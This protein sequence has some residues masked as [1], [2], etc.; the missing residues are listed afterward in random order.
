MKHATKKHKYDPLNSEVKLVGVVE[1]KNSPLLINCLSWYNSMEKY[2]ICDSWLV[3]YMT[4]NG[5]SKNDVSRLIN[6]PSN[7]APF[8]RTCAYLARMTM[9][10]T[11]F[12]GKLEGIVDSKIKNILSFQYTTEQPIAATNVISVQE[13]IKQASVKY[14]VEIEDEIDKWFFEKNYQIVFSL[15]AYL[16]KNKI[17]VPICNHIKA[18]IQPKI[19]EL[20]Q[21]FQGK[22]EQIAEGYSYLSKK[23]AKEILQNLNNLVKD[24]ER[25]TQNT[26]IS[27]PRKQRKKAPVSN[28]KLINK[29]KYQKEFTQLKIT[30]INPVQII[31]A[32]QLWTFNTKYNYITVYNS[33]SSGGLNI[34]GTTLIGY[35]EENSQRK[36]VRK[37]KG[38]VEKILGGSKTSLRNIMTELKTK[39][40]P[41]NGRI[42]EDTILLKV[43]K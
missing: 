29:L 28:E 8:K 30:S 10:G 11:I 20:T 2:D 27:K 9:N 42:N 38:F 40:S 21:A 13:K 34:K 43:L 15:Y 22:D 16:Q 36:K 32:D 7:F 35:S 37:P 17:S 14:C 31:G 26:K 3:D 33:D 6:V 39:E 25:Y 4:K 18:F 5:Y 12:A 24:I 1:E 23:R 19:D 41:L